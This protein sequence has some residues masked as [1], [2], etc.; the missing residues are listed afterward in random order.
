VPVATHNLLFWTSPVFPEASHR[1]VVT[2]DQDTSLG[3][4]VNPLNRTF[5]LDYFVYN[6]TS[7]A[8]KPVV[9]DDSDASVKY[10]T[11]WKAVND[12]DSSLER[13]EHVSGAVGSAV[14][15]S[16]EGTQISLIGPSSQ[17]G[18]K[19]SVIIDGSQPTVIQSQDQNQLFVSSLLP[20]A[21]HTMN[22][23]VLDGNSLAI[24]YFLVTTN[25][26]IPTT[27]ALP[28]AATS[29]PE[30]MQ[31]Q[32][33]A[34]SSAQVSKAPPIAAIV[35][36]AVGGLALLLLLLIGV[37]MWRRRAR[38]V[39]QPAFEYPVTSQPHPWVTKRGSVTSMTTLT[40]DDESRRPKNF[41]KQ[42][43]PS[44]YIYYE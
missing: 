18:F 27:S 5:F 3:A 25:L 42:R 15:L 12:S 43:P 22:I 31:T 7:T 41:E 2:V 32:A 14:A 6:T 11:E 20:Q 30:G 23:T 24:D 29:P 35:G 38:R 26:D 4:S 1:L 39:N 16:F 9:I 13:T 36:G 33:S 17:K 10:S 34:S 21:T 44:R 8:G 40:E 37:L 19:A 28:V